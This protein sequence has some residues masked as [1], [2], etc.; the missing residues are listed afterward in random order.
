MYAALHSYVD[1]RLSY[2]V[3]KG[4]TSPVLAPFLMSSISALSKKLTT[5]PFARL[6]QPVVILQLH[7]YAHYQIS[8]II[9]YLIF[10]DT[11]KFLMAFSIVL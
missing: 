3:I 6:Y 10:V 9:S 4:L 8:R 5:L 11:F 2:T 7:L 1:L